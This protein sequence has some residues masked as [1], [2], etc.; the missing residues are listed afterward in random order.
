MKEKTIKAVFLDIDG[1]LFSHSTNSV[2]ASAEAAVRRAR[3]EGIDIFAA[4]GRH[5]LEL[6]DLGFDMELDGWIT[7]NGALCFNREGICFDAPL[8]D[9]DIDAV[10]K[11]LEEH[12]FPCQFLEK[13]LMYINMD[14]FEV[15]HA[16][17]KIHTPMPPVL[18]PVR[19]RREKTYMLVPW[20]QEEVWHKIF[21]KT[22]NLK[23]TRWTPLAADVLSASAG[24]YRGVLEICRHYGIDPRDTAAFG[25]GP[26]DIE[27]FKAC[28][29]SVA[30]G[31]SSDDV[32]AAADAVCDDIDRDGLAKAFEKYIFNHKE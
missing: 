6:R 23:Y 28:G 10:L 3:E 29:F 8:T 18:D 2:P 16:L 15:R 25:D 24:K 13:D 26:N 22:Q 9:A 11:G 17:E 1:T 30:M 14:S 12:P 4:T 27:L 32:K 19:A 7:L 5:M 20:V 31:N 21:E